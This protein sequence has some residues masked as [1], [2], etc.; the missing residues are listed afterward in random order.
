MTMMGAALSVT[1]PAGATEGGTLGVALTPGRGILA[2]PNFWYIHGTFKFSVEVTDIGGDDDENL[3]VFIS[4]PD[5][6]DVTL[7]SGTRWYCE[8]VDGGV[9]CMNPDYVVPGEAW[10]LLTITARGSTRV[11]DTLDVYAIADSDDE[12][13]VGV[14]FLYDTST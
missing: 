5:E 4:I 9:D 10:P 8:D 3:F 11:S 12:A 1:P 14:P 6:I 13:H 2:S 7:Y